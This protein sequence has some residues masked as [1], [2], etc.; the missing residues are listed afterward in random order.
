MKVIEVK[1]KVKNKKKKLAV[2]TQ[3]ESVGEL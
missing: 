2:S 1:N 3:K